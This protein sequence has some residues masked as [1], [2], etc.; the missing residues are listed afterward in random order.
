MIFFLSKN[1]LVIIRHL[2]RVYY[3]S[4]EHEKNHLFSNYPSTCPSSV[5]S[6]NGRYQFYEFDRRSRRRR[7]ENDR[8]TTSR[9]ERRLL[10]RT[11]RRLSSMVYRRRP[12]TPPT[13]FHFSASSI[14]YPFAR[15]RHDG[16]RARTAFALYGLPFPT[17]QAPRPPTVSSR[18]SHLAKTLLF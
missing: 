11:I 16:G 14:S 1:L 8:E 13:L 10:H 15:R 7:G 3:F 12:K 4:K 6:D 5:S 18:S 9:Q 17:P 2:H